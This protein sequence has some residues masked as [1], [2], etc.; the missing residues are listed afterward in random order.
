[1]RSRSPCKGENAKTI[2]T[3]GVDHDK[4][5]EKTG[6]VRQKGKSATAITSSQSEVGRSELCH[7]GESVFASRPHRRVNLLLSE[8]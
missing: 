4:A 8:E 3:E 5:V 7:C 2:Q 6:G 1:M